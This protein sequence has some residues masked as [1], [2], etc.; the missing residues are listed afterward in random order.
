M[1]LS[2][3]YAYD[4]QEIINYLQ[5]DFEEEMMSISFT[6]KGIDLLTLAGKLLSDDAEALTTVLAGNE[7]L[8]EL[9]SYYVSD[10][11]IRKLLNQKLY[12]VIRRK[13]RLLVEDKAKV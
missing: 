8:E 6:E 4:R 9:M 2:S 5:I 12:A 3:L 11:E 10:K 13:W 7:R 1:L